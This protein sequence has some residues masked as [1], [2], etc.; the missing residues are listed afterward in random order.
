MVDEEHECFPDAW[1]RMS[2]D[3]PMECIICDKWM[4]L[5]EGMDQ[6][7]KYLLH[8]GVLKRVDGKLI[9]TQPMESA[10]KAIRKMLRFALKRP[11]QYV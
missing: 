1:V 5:P 2:G 7:E 11:K 8:L 6:E 9:N 10:I 4:S 3:K